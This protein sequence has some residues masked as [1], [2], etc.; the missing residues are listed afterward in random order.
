MTTGGL[1]IPELPVVVRTQSTGQNWFATTYAKEAVNSDPYY[2]E[3]LVVGD[4]PAGQ[5]EVRFPY[6][7]VI[8]HTFIEIRPG[9]I[10]YLMYQGRK[11]F[12]TEY[13]IAPGLNFQP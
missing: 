2:K 3:N 9:R 12:H 4:L 1:L 5:Y 7:G 11:G 6:A 8:N 13:P 10:T